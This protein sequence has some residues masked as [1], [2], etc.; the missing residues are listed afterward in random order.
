VTEAGF[1]S[2]GEAARR[3]GVKPE[4]V[5][6][7]VSRGLLTSARRPGHRGSVFAADE[8]EDLAARGRAGRS[9]RGALERV[10]T[11]VTALDDDRLYYRGRP[12]A[13]LI[14]SG[15]ESVA[16]LLWSGRPG[17]PTWPPPEPAT[18]RA[19]SAAMGSLPPAARPADRPRWPPS[20]RGV[21]TAGRRR[22]CRPPGP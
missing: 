19:V 12:V 13:E 8:V 3:L 2:T 10:R 5:Y 7:Y 14:G 11:A 9:P 4:T 16:E 18:V 20:T 22:S 21:R 1:L 15:Y 17:P 6:A